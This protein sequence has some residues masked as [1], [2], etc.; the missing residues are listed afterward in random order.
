VLIVYGFAWGLVN[1]GFLV[2]LPVH[3]AKSGV[4]AGQVTTILARAALFAI[5]GSILISQL[6]A[7]WSSR[8]TLITAAALEAATLGVFA[9]SGGTV[10]RHTALFTALV[11]VLLI[12][13]WATISA[14][15]PYSAEIYPTGIRA[16]GAGVV[17]GRPN[18]AACS[19]SAYPSPRSPPKPHRRRAACRSARRTSR[20]DALPL[21]NRNTGQTTRRDL[22]RGNRRTPRRQPA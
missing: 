14:L 2:W 9:T 18:S 3:V 8:G 20:A 21:R 6:Y 16:A 15:A 5:P 12:S 7:R 22:H 4:S 11:V 19:R 10:V 17:A 1:F 13:T